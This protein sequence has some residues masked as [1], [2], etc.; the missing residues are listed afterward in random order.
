[1]TTTRKQYSPKFKA[2][3]GRRRSPI[4]FQAGR[5]LARRSPMRWMGND[6]WRRDFPASKIGIYS[7]TVEGWIDRFGTWRNA[8]IKRMNSGTVDS[9]QDLRMECLTGA[10]L[11]ERSAVPYAH[12]VLGA[13]YLRQGR[14]P[15][16]IAELEQAV[17]LLP[18]AVNYSKLGYAHSVDGDTVQG[19]QELQHALQLDHSSPQ[20]HYLLGLLLLDR[21][22]RNHE[23]YEQ[24][25]WALRTVPSAQMALAV[26]YV[27]GGQDDAADRQVKKFIGSGD[28]ARFAFWKRWVSSVAEQARPSLAFGLRVQ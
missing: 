3:L 12:S 7:Y 19:E 20:T 28:D 14:I 26:C 15:E 22:S 1:M 13:M 6:R 24:L 4:S 5:R 18:I 11:Q 21:R 23:A 25:Q 10:A 16:A 27:R 8:M 9:S 2:R 17:Q